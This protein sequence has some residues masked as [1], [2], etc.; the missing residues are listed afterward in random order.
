MRC[1]RFGTTDGVFWKSPVAFSHERRKPMISTRRLHF[2]VCAAVFALA[3]LGAQGQD[4][5]PPEADKPAAGAVE[6]RFADG[7]ALKM[8]LTDAKID[9]TTPYG[10]L[11]VPVTDIHTMELST[12]VSDDDRKAIEK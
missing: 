11:S 9:I 4:K 8:T 10:K 3:P 12:R 1:R 5:K 2:L 7:T 6:V